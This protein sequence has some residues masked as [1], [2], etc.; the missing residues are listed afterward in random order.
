MVLLWLLSSCSDDGRVERGERGQ[1][2][3]DRI[4]R[5]SVW[6][7]SSEVIGGQSVFV[8]GLH[9]PPIHR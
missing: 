4:D 2:V 5:P 8:S 6:S 7:A 1:G 3:L 9:E